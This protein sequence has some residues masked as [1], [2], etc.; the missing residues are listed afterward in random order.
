VPERASVAGRERPRLFVALVLPEAARD[1][2][3]DW[4]QRELGNVDGIRIVPPDHLH[5][6]IAFLGARP[7][8]DVD[9]IVAFLRRAAAASSPPVLTPVRYRETRSV[10]MVVFDDEARRA[11]ALAA[12]VFTGLEKLGLYEREQR[13]W[14]PHVTVLRFRG[15]PPRLAPVSPALGLVS[16][17]EVALYHSVLRPSGA[18]YE[19]VES[20]ALGG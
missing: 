11:A 6:T 9:P 14:L 13:A 12:D 1:R 20:V 10:G 18:Q 16:P 8:Q 4:Q 15:R 17:S 2:L 3:A 5:I 19:I 7:A